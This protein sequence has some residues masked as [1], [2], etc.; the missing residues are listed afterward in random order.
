VL[1]RNI[2]LCIS[3]GPKRQQTPCNNKNLSEGSCLMLTVNE[4]CLQEYKKKDEHRA[5][6]EQSQMKKRN[7]MVCSLMR[8]WTLTFGTNEKCGQIWCMWERATSA[9]KMISLYCGILPCLS[10]RTTQE[11]WI[12]RIWNARENLAVWSTQPG[13]GHLKSFVTRSA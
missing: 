5:K 1:C 6:V 2:G 13:G 10:G 9:D 11:V 4:H 8:E 3:W 12:S 7:A